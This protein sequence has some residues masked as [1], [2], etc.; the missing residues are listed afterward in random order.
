[1]A[2]DILISLVGFNL[3]VGAAI[4]LAAVMRQPVRHAFGARVAYGLWWLAPPAGV[5]SLLPARSI[6]LPLEPAPLRPLAQATVERI[7]TALAASTLSRGALVLMAI[8]GLG[9]LAGLALL[10]WR[11]RTSLNLLGRLTHEAPGLVRSANPDV[12]PAV[13]GVIRPR[14]ILPLDFEDR[15]DARERTVI[16]AHERAH[17]AAG[18]VRVNVA[19]A[20]VRCVLWFNPLIHLA[21][22]LIRIDQEIACD[23]TVVARHPGDRRA[24]A[25][26][27]LK[28]QVKPAPLPLG[29]YWPA[30]SRNRLKE[31]LLMLT[32]KSPSHGRR[33][34]GGALV[35]VTA[36]GAGYAAWAAQP[37]GPT[38]LAQAAA[39]IVQLAQAAAPPADGA[40]NV[41]KRVIIKHGDGQAVT[42]EGADIPAD[43]QAQIDAATAAGGDGSHRVIKIIRH[44]DGEAVDLSD[45]PSPGPGAHVV[46]IQC[47]KIADGAPPTCVTLEGDPAEAAAA[48]DKFQSGEGLGDGTATRFILRREQR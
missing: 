16:I 19:M 11:Q 40:P 25:Q 31:R 36:L 42:F 34:A 20:L 21:A 28:A 30:R 9:A 15:F 38:V 23:E 43:I 47:H 8:W 1:M 41:V 18:H 6:R 22:A 10:I 29:C 32:R 12:G 37:A 7:D 26:A 2:A 39:P 17:V 48:I 5:A 46:K 44:G 14:I 45:L 24:Y 4:L 27:L 13:V 33:L 3:A 35:A